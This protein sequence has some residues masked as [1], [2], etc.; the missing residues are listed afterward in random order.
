V[1][2]N[3]ARHE[4]AELSQD[5]AP[6]GSDDE[7]EATETEVKA[8]L[9]G[10][11]ER[12]SRLV[13]EHGVKIAGTLRSRCLSP[14]ECADRAAP[15]PQGPA[16]ASGLH[17]ALSASSSKKALVLAYREAEGGCSIEQRILQLQQT[18]SATIPNG[19]PA[20]SA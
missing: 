10:L 15:L 7:L 17:L 4:L 18:L 13:D 16:A 11:K 5:E 6:I 20:G 14:A 2:E 12:G 9:A 8:T 19:Q 1:A 3:A